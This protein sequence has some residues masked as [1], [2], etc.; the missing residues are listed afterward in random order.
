MISII[1]ISGVTTE[2]VVSLGSESSQSFFRIVLE[3][4]GGVIVH[5][6]LIVGQ[7]LGRLTAHGKRFRQPEVDLI[8]FAE[9][10]VVLHDSF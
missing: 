10:R 8:G 6:A 4:A 5:E 2:G 9:S 7:G 1:S 3:V